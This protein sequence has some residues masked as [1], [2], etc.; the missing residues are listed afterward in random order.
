MKFGFVGITALVRRNLARS[1]YAQASLNPDWYYGAHPY[2]L[3]MHTYLDEVTRCQTAL[4][5][6]LFF[7][8]IS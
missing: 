6:S 2:A 4:S 3:M 7:Q 5:T 1:Q 8:H